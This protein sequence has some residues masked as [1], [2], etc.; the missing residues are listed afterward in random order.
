MAWI[1]LTRDDLKGR[2]TKPELDRLPSAARA[3][4]ISSEEILNNAVSA[5]VRE[6]RGYVA[7]RNP[8]GVAGTIPDELENAAMPLM[9]RAIFGRIPG[10]EELYDKVRQEE[11]KD[12]ILLLGRVADGRFAIV[13]PVT[14]APVEE[15]ANTPSPAISERVRNFSLEAQDGV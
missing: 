4:G 8:L 6:I 15:Q 14:E 12:A 10:L 7:V 5:V 9:R 2:L 13:A 11:T 3:Q 1:T